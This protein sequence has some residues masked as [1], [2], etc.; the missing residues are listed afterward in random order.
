MARLTNARLTPRLSHL[1]L[2]DHVADKRLLELAL[3]GLQA[4]KEKIDGEIARIQAQL[5]GRGKARGTAKAAGGG[6]RRKKRN[7][8]AAARKAQSLRMKAYWR[9]RRAREGAKR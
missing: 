1:F 2:E 4:E 8:S 9:D 7:F 6:R 5:R 3:I